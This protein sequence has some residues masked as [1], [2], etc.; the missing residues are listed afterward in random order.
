MLKIGYL[1]IVVQVKLFILE[2]VKKVR[3]IFLNVISLNG[4]HKS[5]AGT[6]KFQ[7]WC[8]R[9]SS[10]PLGSEASALNY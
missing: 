6:K 10:V 1:W 8:R 7:R 5:V 3:S 4:T 9:S 2:M